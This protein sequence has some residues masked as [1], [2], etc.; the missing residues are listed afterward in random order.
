MAEDKKDVFDSGF[1]REQGYYAL[2][3]AKMGYRLSYKE[4]NPQGKKY[5][6]WILYKLHRELG[7]PLVPLPEL[8]KIQWNKTCGSAKGYDGKWL[9]A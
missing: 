2:K 3:K 8:R 7:I 4:N 1:T 6:A 5:Y 9:Y